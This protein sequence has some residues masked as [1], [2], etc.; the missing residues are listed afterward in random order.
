MKTLIIGFLIL[1]G[2][3]SLSTHIWVCDVKGLCNDK[4]INQFDTSGVQL[5]IAAEKDEVPGNMLIYFEFD[6][7]EFRADSLT[8]RYFAESKTYLDKNSQALLTITGYTD[9]IGSDDYNQ[10]LGYRRAK[11][12]QDYFSIRGMPAD[13]MVIASKGE[14]EPAADNNTETGRSSNRRAVI[15][16]KK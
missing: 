4:V 3:S 1:A 7:S 14:Y 10:A 2:W 6:K 16:I 9:A 12:M 11:T 13:K 5:A 15:N 8:D